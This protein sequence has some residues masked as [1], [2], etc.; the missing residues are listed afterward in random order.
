MCIKKIEV[1]ITTCLVSLLFL[2]KQDVAYKRVFIFHNRVFSRKH[3]FLR[4]IKNPHFFIKNSEGKIVGYEQE[5]ADQLFNEIKVLCYIFTHQ[6]NHAKVL[7]VR[8]TWGNKC[9]KLIFMSDT[10]VPDQPDIITL[11]VENGRMHLREKT[12]LALKYVY[13]NYIND[14]DWFLRAD[15]DK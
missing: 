13:D 1:L 6:L 8:N 3:I 4:H 15:D 9:N 14:Y 12:R 7:H 2:N 11:A 10:V 5:K